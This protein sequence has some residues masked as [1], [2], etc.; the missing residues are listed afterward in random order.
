MNAQPH[1][2]DIVLEPEDNER[3]AGLCGAFDQHLRQI[4]R[5]LGVEINNRGV[6]FRIIGEAAAASVTAE[7]LR[8]LYAE[9]KKS[10]LTPERIHLS[11]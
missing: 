8:D 10:P 5:R 7:L 11:L 6:K 3:L 4:E 9:T 2:I 1:T